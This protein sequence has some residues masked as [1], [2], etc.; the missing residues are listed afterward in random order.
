MKTPVTLSYETADSA[1]IETGIGEGD[2]VV[3]KADEEGMADG[4]R[5]RKK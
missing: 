1:V 5:I 3:S 2:M 4:I